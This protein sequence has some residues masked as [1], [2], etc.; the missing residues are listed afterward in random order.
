MAQLCRQAVP[1]RHQLA[2]LQNIDA[3]LCGFQ[4]LIR[5]FALLTNMALF[6]SF[7]TS[8]TAFTALSAWPSRFP[9]ARILLSP[10][11]LLKPYSAATIPGSRI[12]P[13]GYTRSVD[14][15]PEAF[16]HQ[17]EKEKAAVV[18]VTHFQLQ[19]IGVGPAD[20][21]GFR[22]QDRLA[23]LLLPIT[24]RQSDKRLPSCFW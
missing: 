22:V 14:F 20:T 9:L 13:S 17:V 21:A 18:F 4:N 5:A 3:V 2:G 19:V 15:P 10:Q 8:S 23:A 1:H 6:S 12:V 7:R 24:E 11:F 16:N